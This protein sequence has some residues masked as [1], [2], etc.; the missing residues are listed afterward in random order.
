MKI[1]DN[2]EKKKAVT[3]FRSIQVCEP[4]E[5][6]LE[7]EEKEFRGSNLEEYEDLDEEDNIIPKKQKS[8]SVHLEIVDPYLPFA[9]LGL[10]VKSN[11]AFIS[12]LIFNALSNSFEKIDEGKVYLAISELK[13]KKFIIETSEGFKGSEKG[14]AIYKNF[15]KNGGMK[16][17]V[18]KANQFLTYK[19]L[20]N[21]RKM[22]KEGFVVTVTDYYLMKD[23][24][25]FYIL[26]EKT[27]HPD[28]KIAII[29]FGGKS[30]ISHVFN[31]EIHEGQKAHTNN[32]DYL[33]PADTWFWVA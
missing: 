18:Q 23:G 16:L 21:P 27:V 25:E 20:K 5:S 24:R 19:K 8:K 26:S 29:S 4:C 10:I 28:C 9:V 17:M 33:L 13:R 15:I 12:K 30:E 2:C 32:L 11:R 31:T 14:E 7:K 6:I 22:K 3:K 1:C